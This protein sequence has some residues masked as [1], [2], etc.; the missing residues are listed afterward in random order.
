[1]DDAEYFRARALLCL[2]LAHQMSSPKDG[3][4]LREQALQ[5][6]QR[7]EVLERELRQKRDE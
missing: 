5:Y 7:A 3:D 2:N 4:T 6:A 1:M